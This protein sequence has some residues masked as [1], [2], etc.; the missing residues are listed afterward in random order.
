M[1]Q[2]DFTKKLLGIEDKNIKIIDQVTHATH[3]ELIAELDYTPP[4]C[5]HCNGQTSKYDRQR[6][7]RIP[8]LEIAGMKTVILLRKRRFKCKQCSRVMVAQ[9]T[10]VKKNHQI[11]EP[12]RLKILEKL[13]SKESLTHISRDLGVSP[14]TVY[15]KLQQVE[16][17]SSATS[18]PKHLAWDEFAFVKGKM[19]FIAQDFETK[20]IVTILDGRTEA[21]IK[22]FFY[23][24]TYKQRA[25]VKTVTMDMYQPY[26]LLAKKLF[27]NAKIIL[28]RFHIIQHLSRSFNQ[29]RIQIM[30]QFDRK[31]KPYKAIKRYWKLLQ[32]DS[33]RLNTKRF[34]RPM[35]KQH[36][37][38]E[39]ILQKLLAYSDELHDYYQLYQMLL[40]HFNDRNHKLFFELI[41]AN[42][43]KVNQRFLTTFKTFN[44]YKKE[45]KNAFDLS[46]S[47]AK[48]EATNNLIKV[49][50]RNAYG[51]RNFLN[52]KRRIYLAINY[53]V[54][55][56]PIILSRQNRVGNIF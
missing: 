39:E 26:V 51:F 52:F 41:D 11:S 33:K 38:N 24:F 53:K 49:I 8:Y 30:N 40:A 42:K 13:H 45:I 28:D 5:Y 6:P 37:T 54:I 9:T 27:P 36:L 15:R 44:K 2:L 34:Y 20:R 23:R 55:S 4:R 17:N 12:V 43:D 19:S 46:Y 32:Q 22:Q 50:K 3:K 35:F 31:S 16:V 1:E 47:N 25:K 10:L 7:S 29:T 48:I 56:E 18:L 14:T 21:V